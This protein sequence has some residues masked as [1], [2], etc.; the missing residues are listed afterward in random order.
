MNRILALL[1]NPACPDG[2]DNIEANPS[3]EKKNER[4]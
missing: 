2:M 4:H 3:K 1:R